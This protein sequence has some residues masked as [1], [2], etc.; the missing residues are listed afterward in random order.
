M[1][2]RFKP[3]ENKPKTSPLR[4]FKDIAGSALT[5]TKRQD[6]AVKTEAGYQKLVNDYKRRMPKDLPPEVKET[7]EK[8]LLKLIRQGKFKKA[9][10][11]FKGLSD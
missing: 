7:A 3:I 8:Q 1:A 2:T 6:L 5:Y 4:R 11:Y 9:R 10:E